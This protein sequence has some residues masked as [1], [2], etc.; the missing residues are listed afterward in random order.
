LRHSD[1][2]VCSRGTE[3]SLFIEEAYRR[4]G[5]AI[6]SAGQWLLACMGQGMRPNRDAANPASCGLAKKLGY[7]AAGMHEATFHKLK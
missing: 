4:Q 1:S 3:V 2:L 7:S 5:V 6:A